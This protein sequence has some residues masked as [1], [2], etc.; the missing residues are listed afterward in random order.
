MT[1]LWAELRYGIDTYPL[2]YALWGIV[3]LSWLYALARLMGYLA[4][5]R[6]V[7]RADQALQRLGRMLVDSIGQLPIWRV[8]LA[9]L[10]H[11]GLFGG[12]ALLLVAFVASHFLWPRGQPWQK[13]TWVHTVNDLG[14]V[15]VLL[16]LI[17]A[18]WRRQVRRQLPAGGTEIALWGLLMAGNLLALLSYALLVATAQPEWRAQA[19]VSNALAGL[20]MPLGKGTL[21]AMYGW[22]WALLHGLVWAGA[23]LTPWVKWRH[24]LLT[25]LSL[26]SRRRAPLGRMDALSLE[27]EGPYG[28]QCPQDLTWKEAVDLV[29]CTRCGRCTRACPAHMAGRTLDP[30]ALMEA[31]Q[32]A[33]GKRPLAEQVGVGVL[34][35]CTTCMACED[36][37][38]V[39]ISPLSL[40]MDL[41]RERVLDAARFP[42][43]LQNVLRGLEQQG[44]SWNL[45]R[46][47]REHW[48]SSLG[49]PILAEG[50]SCEVLLWLGCMGRYDQ[51]ARKTVGALV[52]LLRGAQVAVAT[53][54]RD[55]DC[56]GDPARRTGNEYLWR[57]LAERNGESL[58]ARRFERLV[59]L[60]PHCI[61]TMANE[62]GDLGLSLPAVHA[63]TYLEELLDAGR[64]PLRSAPAQTLRL[65][66]HDP[67]YLGRGN[68]IYSPAR[69]L[70]SALP[71]VQLAE[72]GQHGREALCCGGGGGQMWL[73]SEGQPHLEA[74]R[75]QE[76]LRSG[77]AVCATACPYCATMLSD[78]LANLQA[79]I[80][81]CD[82]VE[83]L[84]DHLALD[85]ISGRTDAIGA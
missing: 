81:V 22:S 85:V 51:R 65:T 28:A 77:S 67:C 54:G 82:V 12:S 10:M 83:L 76:V 53:L 1:V 75:V 78:G 24:I 46:L 71:G 49:L 58:R 60:C 43:P 15:L 48:I 13:A 62:Y 4:K 20:L 16:G 27:G 34:W 11:L 23:L 33:G 19:W 73:G 66:Y 70:I 7:R 21:R 9:G 39:G 25:P 29:S 72:L 57:K 59:S 37:C 64:L 61:N 44:N 3:A 8:R 52:R 56:C 50:E 68:G 47:E 5:R 2:L 26:F 45:P 38:P 18:A 32:P 30:L 79:D 42:S 80:A 14:M 31:V 55:E 6:P 40:V 35:D 74:A 17:I 84:A 69:K 63:T 41:R 36:V